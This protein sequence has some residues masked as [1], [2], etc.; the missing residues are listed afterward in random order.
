MRR[1]SEMTDNTENVNGIEIY[2]HDIYYFTDE[3]IKNELDGDKD[4][5]HDCFPQLLL[6]LS[7][8]IQKPANEDIALLDAIFNIYV[9]L[10]TKYRILPTLEMFSILVKINKST[11]TDWK[12]GEYR[13]SSDHGKTVKT[14]L[15]T[16]KNFVIDRL[17]NS[18]GKADV[19]LIFIAKAGYQ[20]RETSPVSPVETENRC[21]LT[22]AELPRLGDMN[23]NDEMSLPDFTE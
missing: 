7:D 14:W 17:H 6:Y 21:V 10:C 22:A 16:C 5:V 15:E 9:R 23:V 1:C 11:F 18:S 2:L 19:N 3:F 8:R 13:K 12:N 20:M 4:A